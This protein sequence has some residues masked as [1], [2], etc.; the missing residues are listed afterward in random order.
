MR[1]HMVE[2]LSRELSLTADQRNRLD[3]VMERQ[4]AA[5]QKIQEETR[6]RI[7]ALLD[8]SRVEIEKLLTPDQR[9]RFKR[10]QD[11][12]EGHWGGPPQ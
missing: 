7:R 4:A 1:R 2:R 11:R 3:S 12:A 5:F 8:S 10:L 6:P 9:E